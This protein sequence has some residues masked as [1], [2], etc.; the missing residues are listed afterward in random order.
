MCFVGVGNKNK[1]YKSMPSKR[2]TAEAYFLFKKVL[3][4][5]KQFTKKKRIS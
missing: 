4:S 3:V 1:V 5:T 2:E